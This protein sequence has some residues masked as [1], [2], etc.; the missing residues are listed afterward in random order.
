MNSQL[1]ITN[2][3]SII[4]LL[5]TLVKD[6]RVKATKNFQLLQRQPTNPKYTLDK[7]SEVCL[8]NFLTWKT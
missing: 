2:F 6:Q 3:N 5:K 4:L 7:I 1:E 8:I